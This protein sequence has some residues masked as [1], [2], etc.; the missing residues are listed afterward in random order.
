MEN[1]VKRQ[2]IRYGIAAFLLAIILGATIYSFGNTFTRFG[3]NVSPVPAAHSLLLPS[4]SSI[5][6]LKHFLKTN[7]QDQ[8]IFW[9]YGPLDAQMFS[10]GSSLVPGSVRSNTF[11][12]T[13]Q[14]SATN[15]QVAGVDEADTVKVDDRGF[16]YILSNDT[17][18]IVA[19]YPTSHASVLS[20]LKFNSMIWF[21]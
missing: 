9:L 2:A 14:H 13:V 11:A 12:D 6:D 19:A 21:R 5:D 20:K 3:S 8:G 1:Q 17:V 15:V 7:S 16:V 4:F 18:Y 10:L